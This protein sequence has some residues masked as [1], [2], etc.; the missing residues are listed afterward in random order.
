VIGRCHADL[1]LRYKTNTEAGSSGSPCFTM[2]WTLVALHHLG[3]PA[4][5]PAPA[6]NQ[7]IPIE[8]I[9]QRIVAQGQAAAIGLQ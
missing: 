7:G 5:A 2:D 8:L 9:R 4:R 3:D 1:R 6:F